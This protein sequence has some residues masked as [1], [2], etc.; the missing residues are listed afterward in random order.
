MSTTRKFYAYLAI[1]VF[2]F[3]LGLTFLPQAIGT[4]MD[5]ECGFSVWEIVVS[6]A[7]PLA[8]IVFPVLLEM[9]LY[10]KGLTQALSDIGITRF[11]WTGIRIAIIYLLPL[12][13]FFPLVALLTNSP[14]TMRTHWEWL[15]V[16]I[17]LVN[18]L[19]EEI[20][21]RGYVFRH[22]REER[23]FWRAAT[24]STV[25]F[26]LYHFPIII[27]QG[28]VV[29][30]VAVVLAIPLGYLTAYIYERDKKTVWGPG[31]LHFG[32][33]GLVMLLVLP[34]DIQPIA[35]SLYMLLGIIVSGL[36]LMRAYRSGFGREQSHPTHE[37]V[38]L[39][40]VPGA[41]AL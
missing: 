8:F 35:S 10:R 2:S 12:I 19:A 14:I 22:L 27:T 6:F 5:G 32:N 17:L 38:E 13:A 26:A 30:S 20:L 21:M 23:P 39:I 37:E 4:C 25:Y 11:S 41:S 1:I 9:V 33:N 34:D 15:V 3:Y 16:N 7:V 31:L 24:L 40:P 36:M 29:G 28:I 18:G